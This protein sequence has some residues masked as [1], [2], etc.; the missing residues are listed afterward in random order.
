MLWRNSNLQLKKFEEK[1]TRKGDD[2]TKCPMFKRIVFLKPH[3]KWNKGKG[4]TQWF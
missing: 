1:N 2:G 3:D 4:S